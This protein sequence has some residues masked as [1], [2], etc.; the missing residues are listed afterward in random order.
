M[1]FSLACFPRGWGWFVK[2]SPLGYTQFR[3]T[4]QLVAVSGLFDAEAEQNADKSES[5]P[6]VMKVKANRSVCCAKHDKGLHQ[7][8]S[9]SCNKFIQDGEQ[10]SRSVRVGD[11]FARSNFHQTVILVYSIVMVHPSI[12]MTLVLQRSLQKQPS[13]FLLLLHYLGRSTE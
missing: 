10:C 8:V 1:P 9:T 2:N 7:L 4:H 11:D 3:C 13:F 5:C 6:P 12:I